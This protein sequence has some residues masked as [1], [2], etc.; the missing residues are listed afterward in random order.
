M[1]ITSFVT[2]QKDSPAVKIEVS[3]DNRAKDH[4]LRVLFPTNVT[5]DKYFAGQAFYQVERKTGFDRKTV[6]YREP[7]VP[8]RN[9]NGIV[10]KRGADGCGIAFV[11]AEGLHEAACLT[12]EKVPLP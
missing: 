11:S 2:V 3:V 12:T 9:M 4:R 1:R 10:G 7:D 8:E 5:G 6:S